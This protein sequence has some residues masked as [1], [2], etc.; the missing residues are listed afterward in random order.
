MFM[1]T[2][3]TDAE[4]TCISI[5]DIHDAAQYSGTSIKEVLSICGLTKRDYVLKLLQELSPSEKSLIVNTYHALRKYRDQ[6]A[7]QPGKSSQTAR[8]LWLGGLKK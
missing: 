6:L 3:F 2:G 4:K 8:Q 5:T 1:R 7:Q